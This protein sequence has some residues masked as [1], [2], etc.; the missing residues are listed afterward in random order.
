MPQLNTIDRERAIG[1][2][3]AGVTKSAVANDLGVAVSIIF[4]LCTPF[5]ATGN[6]LD[7]KRRGRPRVTSVQQDRRIYH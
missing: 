4:R 3:Q 1:R 7:Q 2:L 6:T 5:Q